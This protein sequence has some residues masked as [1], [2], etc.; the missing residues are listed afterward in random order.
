MPTLRLP[1]LAQAL[2]LYLAA[3]AIFA[4]ILFATPGFLGTDDYYHTRM[5]VEILEQRSLRVEF[6]WLPL[7]ILSPDKFT[8]HH[9]LFHMYVA[10]FTLLGEVTGAK[11]ATVS[12]AAGV[13]LA[14]WVLLRRMGVRYAWLWALGLFVVSLPFINRILMIRTQGASLLLL[15]V[16][17]IALQAGRYR[18]L[19]PLS[20]A[21]VWLYNG[22][23]LMP[24]FAG[25]YCAAAWVVERKFEP[26]PLIYALLG[27][28]LGLVINPYFPQNLTFIWDHLIAKVDIESSVRL[29]NEWYPYDTGDLLANSAGA[30]IVL[31]LGVVAPN[32]RGAQ[33]KRDRMET[34]LLLCALVTLFML[35]RSRRFIEYFPAFALLYGAVSWGRGI[36]FA[37]WLPTRLAWR[38]LVPLAGALGL[39]YFAY[40]VLP[41]A[42]D[43]AEDSRSPDYYAG[44][45]VWLRA[46]VP[47][48][49][50]I[51]QTD[52]DDFT[53][54][55]YYNPD[56]PYI[57][58]LDPT[59]LQLADPIQWDQ[60]VA[61]TRGEVE[62]PSTLISSVFGAQY[63]V[64][65]AGHD[66]FR[67]QAAADTAME[68]VY[69]DRYNYVWRINPVESP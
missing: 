18:W 33:S 43:Q 24:A 53:R 38:P 7:T 40:T 1:A 25:L 62:T 66:A 16:A 50:M 35:M 64:S 34:T 11:I 60:W 3:F 63:V 47:D 44:A 37:A 23:I 10:P 56:N 2:A 31:A 4:V 36:D 6:P 30:L 69:Q 15:I 39:L 55:F 68:L 28:A 46:N 13:V 8:D 12:I 14:I 59:Y 42:Y 22:F 21:Y 67:Q 52:W 57:V 9:L 17:L 48:G 41:A 32:L 45:G 58:G 20:F 51:F 49:E 27:M 5:A 29:G 65:D 26:R 19:I 54:L 61:L